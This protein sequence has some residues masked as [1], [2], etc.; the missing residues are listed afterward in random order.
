[1]SPDIEFFPALG[2]ST[3]YFRT[4]IGD[5]VIAS[6]FNTWYDIHINIYPNIID[7]T[8]PLVNCT[9]AMLSLCGASVNSLQLDPAN[10]N[11]FVYD[12][13][14]QSV[15]AAHI[16]LN[17]AQLELT[18][19]FPETSQLYFSPDGKLIYATTATSVDVYTLQ[20]ITGTVTLGSTLPITGASVFPAIRQ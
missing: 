7:P 5:S 18:Y 3:S 17:T 1:M 4:A 19:T 11:I 16:N 15:S 12:G 20:P 13:F 14:P 10:Q 9:S 2:D 6:Y 8:I